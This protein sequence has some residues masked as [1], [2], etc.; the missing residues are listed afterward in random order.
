MTDINEIVAGFEKFDIQS[1]DPKWSS[2][3]LERFFEAALNQPQAS[4]TDVFRGF[5]LALKKHHV[6][7]TE[8]VA[9]LVKDVVRTAFSIHKAA[10]AKAEWGWASDELATES[11]AAQC[12]LF[13]LALPPDKLT[14][15][16]VVAILRGLEGTPQ[17][18]EAIVNLSDDLERPDVKQELQRWRASNMG[19][20]AVAKLQAYL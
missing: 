13:M 16:V 20:A 15:A 1:N 11:S 2:W 12:Y 5:N 17:L 9:N 4:M 14:S 8:T 3:L 7:L 19:S 6:K 10:Y 18:D